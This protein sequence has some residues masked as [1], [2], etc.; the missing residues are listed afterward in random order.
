MHHPLAMTTEPTKEND[1]D[2]DNLE[3]RLQ[4]F[5]NEVALI[6]IVF[7]WGVGK[8]LRRRSAG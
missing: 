4:T 3:S 8:D 7:A 1:L 6:D 5:W 2:R